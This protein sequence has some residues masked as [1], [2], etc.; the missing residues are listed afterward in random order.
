M[1]RDQKK[2]YNNYRFL[3][4]QKSKSKNLDVL[5]IDP[6]KIVLEDIDFKTFDWGTPLGQIIHNIRLPE[7]KLRLAH[8]RIIKAIYMLKTDFPTITDMLNHLRKVATYQVN[9]AAVDRNFNLYY[10]PTFIYCLPLHFV[11]TVLAHEAFHYLNNTFKR[12]DWTAKKLKYSV[13]GQTWNIATDLT[14]NYELVRSGFQFPKGFFVPDKEGNFDFS[15]VNMKGGNIDISKNTSEE[16][17]NFLI[18]NKQKTPPQKG[19]GPG[20]TPPYIPKVGDIVGDTETNTKRRV[21]KVDT[22]NKTVKTEP[23]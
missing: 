13:D 7:E 18:K 19:G 23:I 14:M 17:Y 12:E 16:V 3:K 5:V 4:E 22:M 15:N 8:D 9:T 1:N 2:I 6:S 11:A 10:N 20:P 21:V